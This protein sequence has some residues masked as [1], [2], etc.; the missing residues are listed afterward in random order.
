MGRRLIVFE[1]RYG[2]SSIYAMYMG[3]TYTGLRYE[4][5][6]EV[7]LRG[8]CNPGCL[9][10]R[11][12]RLDDNAVDSAIIV[13]DVDSVQ[14]PELPMLPEEFKRHAVNNVNITFV[15]IVWCAETVALKL[16]GQNIDELM[17]NAKVVG[18]MLKD[19]SGISN[20][21]RTSDTLSLIN[22]RSELDV[23]ASRESV[24]KKSL[25][26]LLYGE[27]AYTKPEAIEFLASL[28]PQRFIEVD[29]YRFD[30]NKFP[31]SVRDSAERYIRDN[32]KACKEYGIKT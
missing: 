11:Q 20:F 1:D 8:E 22:V 24:N 25:H 30:L 13:H 32:F 28:R 19:I 3:Y 2:M 23:Y 6:S 27:P 31:E 26:A 10:I 12:A 17:G 9:K 18:K 15:P 16:L 4:T 5:D 21:K 29:G 7:I 14:H